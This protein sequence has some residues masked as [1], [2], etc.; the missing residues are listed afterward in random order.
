MLYNV[1]LDDIQDDDNDLELLD[2]ILKNAASNKV[3]NISTNTEED[4]AKVNDAFTKQEV[5]NKY[6]GDPVKVN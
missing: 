4:K 1:K 2:A 3:D 6:D 5:N